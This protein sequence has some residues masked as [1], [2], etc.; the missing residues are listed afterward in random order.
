MADTAVELNERYKVGKV[1]A[2]YDLTAFHEELPDRWLGKGRE[3]QSLREL[4]DDL[5]VELLRAAMKSANIEPLDGEVQNTY[6][7]LT[8]E[9]V[10]SGMRTAKR[11]ELERE[12]IDVD[13]VEGDFVTH[14]AIYTYLT[15]V[16]D[17]SKEEQDDLD[18]V[19]KHSDRINRLRSR[20]EAVSADSIESLMNNDAIEVGEPEV[21][22]TIQVY[23]Q[24]CRRQ[25]TLSTLLSQ[26]GCD[27]RN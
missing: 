17:V 6:R 9:E 4:A 18:P 3:A 7:L 21:S 5:N 19:E 23:C 1:I 24:E 11:N 8:G 12:G 26:G 20:T 27:C 16:L 22:V 2:K 25:Y 10:S 15:E 13:S 14:Q